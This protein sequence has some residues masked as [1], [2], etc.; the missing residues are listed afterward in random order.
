MITTRADAVAL[1]VADPLAPFRD[2][3]ALPEGVVYLDGN[4]LGAR[5]R[6]AT[7][8]ARRVVEDEWGTGLIRSWNGADW[9]RLP[10]RLGDQ[11]S[12]IIGGGAGETVVTDTT[13]LNLFKALASALR[14]AE[15]D[16]PNRRVIVSE[17]DNFPTDLYIAEGLVELLDR[18]YRLRLIDGDHSLDDLLT[19]QV[20]VLMLSHVNYRTG[21]LWDMAAVTARARERGV[22]VIWDLAHSAGALPVDVTAA[23]A[24]FAVGCTYKYLNGGPGSPG[25][26]WVHRRHQDRF[27]SPLAGGGTPGRSRWRTASNRSPASTASC[28]APSRSS[29]CRWWAAVWTSPAG[30]IWPRYA[31]SRW[32][33]ATCSW[34]WSSS[35]APRTR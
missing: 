9:F 19:D 5:P 8:V 14:I 10:G 21:A 18:G 32:H 15:A 31:A 2:E 34:P 1:D 24:D 30:R 11:L 25:F 4:S 13:S 7:E 28:A 20:A 33:S 22:L 35:A 27:W 17:R 26:V 16:R 6:A 23:G 29:R 12:V 3:F